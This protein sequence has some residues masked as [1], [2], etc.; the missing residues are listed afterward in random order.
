MN[1]TR[2]TINTILKEIETGMQ[3]T[4]GGKNT[5]E[6]ISILLQSDKSGQNRS[7]IHE[8]HN[9]RFDM[10]ELEKRLYT[11]SHYRQLS[12]YYPIYSNRRFIGSLI[13]L[14]KRICRRLL[15]FLI[16]PIVDSQNSINANVVSVLDAYHNNAIVSQAFIDTS[17]Q[18]LREM[19]E[20]I[21]V[22][23]ELYQKTDAQQQGMNMR[24][25]ELV[26]QQREMDVR[27]QEFDAQQQ[28]LVKDSND[29]VDEQKRM[30][31]RLA[32]MGGS[33]D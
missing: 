12:Y 22:L 13:V 8:Q 26:A 14:F 10:D 28:Y 18:L 30:N 5:S 21:R 20:K 11:N 7:D 3:T 1:K 25:Q 2:D 6:I 9:F 23:N 33:Y 4:G 15:K 16:V 24:Q 19:D 29:L 27:Q 32:E 17:E 31:S